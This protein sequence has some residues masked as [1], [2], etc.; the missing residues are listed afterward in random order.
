MIADLTG[1][2]AFLFRPPFGEYNNTVITAADS[3]GYY[4]IQWSIDSL[5]WKN[6]SAEEIYQRVMTKI[7]SGDIVL[8]HNA[9]KHTPEAIRRIIPDL[10]EMGYE[11]IRISQLIH[12]ENYYIDANG[13]QH[14]RKGE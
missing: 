9:G 5:D 3:V 14:L 7:G 13:I 12:R 10:E 6:L 2:Q 11:I 4:T 1:Q 8:F